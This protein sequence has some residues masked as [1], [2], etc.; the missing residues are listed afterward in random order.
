MRVRLCLAAL[1]SLLVLIPNTAQAA[2]TP[3]KDRGLVIGPPRDYANVSPGGVA[4]KKVT[5]ENQTGKPLDITM[6]VEQFSVADYTYQ[7]KFNK[8]QTQND[9][10]HL[11]LTRV[12]LQPGKSQVINYSL[13]PPKTTSPGGHYFTVFA[14]ATI[15]QGT[16]KSQVRAASILYV[17]VDG[18]LQTSSVIQQASIPKVAFGDI[19]FVLQVKNTGN[20]HFFAYVSGKLDGLAVKDKGPA[21]THLLLPQTIRKVGSTIPAPLLPGLYSV[22][23]GYTT[24]K[25]DTV[26]ETSHLIYIP[27]WFLAALAGLAWLGVFLLR[28]RRGL[29][30]FRGF[31]RRPYR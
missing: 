20:T 8:M 9:W 6:S 15:D 2:D 12:Q 21:N 27:L 30:V 4:H 3:P 5:I 16:S 1:C 26:H 22:V 29:R 18:E 19:S 25:G 7:Y 14:T 23:Y 28:R 31:S 17:T 10:L 11:G 13:A 24:D